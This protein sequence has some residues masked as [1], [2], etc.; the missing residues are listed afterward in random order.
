[1]PLHQWTAARLHRDSAWNNAYVVYRCVGK[2]AEGSLSF[3]IP[4]FLIRNPQIPKGR[5]RTSNS[6]DAAGVHGWHRS[7]PLSVPKAHLI[8]YFGKNITRCLKIYLWR[9]FIHNTFT[10]YNARQNLTPSRIMN[11]NS[12]ISSEHGVSFRR[13]ISMT[14]IVLKWRTTYLTDSHRCFM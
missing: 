7:L 1:M 14:L 4:N 11:V 13:L 5:Q 12:W 6:S 8:T 9:Y 2:V 3:P 10:C